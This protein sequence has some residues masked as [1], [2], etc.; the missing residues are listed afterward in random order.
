MFVV[1]DVKRVVRGALEV[2]R[3]ASGQLPPTNYGFKVVLGPNEIMWKSSRPLA[4]T[5]SVVLLLT[6]LNISAVQ[7]SVA[8][9]GPQA[10][11]HILPIL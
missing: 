1:L 11:N 5:N 3:L 9:F 6:F 8:R 4:T 10:R 2:A 7:R